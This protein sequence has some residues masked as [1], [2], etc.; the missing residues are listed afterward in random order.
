MRRFELTP[1]FRRCRLRAH[2]LIRR[3]RAEPPDLHAAFAR[4]SANL[5]VLGEFCELVREMLVL[6]SAIWLRDHRRQRV[7]RLRL[8]GL[9][10]VYACV[11]PAF[12]LDGE[13]GA[14]RVSAST[15][16]SAR[17]TPIRRPS[18]SPGASVRGAIP[19]RLQ[20]C[21]RAV[22]RLAYS[23]TTAKEADRG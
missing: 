8:R 12:H 18:S 5:T 1:L 2:R 9:S 15:Q 22:V 4:E 21:L 16:T 20:W 3:A 17:R 23:R 10:E 6:A 19:P 14:E 13:R 11:S 7:R